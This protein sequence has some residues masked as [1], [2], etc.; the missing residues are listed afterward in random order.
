MM[1][2]V[3]QIRELKQRAID[4]L[5]EADIPDRVIS[6]FHTEFNDTSAAIKLSDSVSQEIQP[7][8]A[9]LTPEQIE[10]CEFIEAS[11]AYLNVFATFNDE[12]WMIRPVWQNHK[13]KFIDM[14]LERAGMKQNHS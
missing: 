2:S 9:R 13:N 6:A 11:K 14:E 5:H 8:I 12:E 10:L 3:S 1:K 7:V 4:L